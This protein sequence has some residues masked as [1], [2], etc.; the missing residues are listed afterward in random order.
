MPGGWVGGVEVD[1]EE[2][3]EE[4]K[5]EVGRDGRAW[6]AVS[7]GHFPETSTLF[8]SYETQLVLAVCC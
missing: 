3:E 5:V 1:E 2:E 6:S 7:A 4:L 8:K